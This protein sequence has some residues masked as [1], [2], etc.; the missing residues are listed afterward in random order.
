MCGL[1]VG[2]GLGLSLLPFFLK[3]LGT[4]IRHFAGIGLVNVSVTV[5]TTRGWQKFQCHTNKLF[6]MLAECLS[7]FARLA[8]FCQLRVYKMLTLTVTLTLTQ[9]CS[10][11]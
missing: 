2:L 9:C 5:C 7:D 3:Y 8:K 1:R 4:D 6:A 10:D 11:C